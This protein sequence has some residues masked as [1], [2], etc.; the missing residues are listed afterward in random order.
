MEEVEGNLQELVFDHMHAI[1]F[2]GTPLAQTILG[3]TQNIQ[4]VKDLFP[5]FWITDLFF[6]FKIQRF[7]CVCT[8]FY[9]EG[10]EAQ[11]ICG[12]KK[13]LV[14]KFCL[15]KKISNNSLEKILNQKFV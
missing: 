11:G 6:R 9:A 1:A 7:F 3:P 10:S 4:W 12:L 5:S 13:P 14:Q 2:Q 8:D 15:E